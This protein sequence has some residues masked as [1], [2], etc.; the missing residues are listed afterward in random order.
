LLLLSLLLLQILQLVPLVLLLLPAVF[1]CFRRCC[2][3]C[4]LCLATHI[5]M[6]PN[7][8]NVCD[9]CHLG[10]NTMQSINQNK[11]NPINQSNMKS[12]GSTQM[13]PSI[14]PKITQ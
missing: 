1:N 3:L 14:K 10:N 12:L 6:L 7:R 2:C 13:K 9:H 8:N 4:H 11:T 5:S